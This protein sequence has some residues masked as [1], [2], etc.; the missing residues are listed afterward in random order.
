MNKRIALLYVFLLVQAIAFAQ[1]ES[2]LKEFGYASLEAKG[3]GAEKCTDFVFSIEDPGIE[4]FPIISIKAGFFP[5]AIGEA[6]ISLSLNNKFLERLGVEDFKCRV[7]EC[8]ARVEIDRNEL[9]KENSLKACIKTGRTITRIVLSNE[10]LIGYYKKPIF[11]QEEFKKCIL[12]ETGKCVE[13]YEA[14]L[15]EDLNIIVSLVNSGTALSVVDLNN[16]KELAGTRA[17]RKEIGQTHFEG[18]IKPGETKTLSYTIRIEKAVPMTLPPAIASYKNAFGEDS[19]IS[20]NLVFIYPKSQPEINCVIGIESIDHSLKE[21][22]LTLTVFNKETVELSNIKIRLLPGK[23]LELVEGSNETVLPSLEP[24]QAK[25]I[26]VRVK[27]SEQG[28]FSIGC[29]LS[30]E[31]LEE[32][33]CTQITI[34]FKEENPFLLVWATI[35]ILTITTTIYFFI[36]TREEYGENT[37]KA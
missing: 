33:E 6:G 8:W 27:A 17:S 20:S 19:Q 5:Q 30:A 22:R 24:K 31:G 21:A 36:H 4:Y 9:A 26:N 14:S 23:G 13:S 29:T 10:S 12:L 7:G 3:I 37:K 11:K 35:V 32:K 15:G 28:E 34:S 25:S 18:V 1:S 2:S 16:R